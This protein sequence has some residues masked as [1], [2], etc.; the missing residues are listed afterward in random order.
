VKR[1]I[2]TETT[3]YECIAAPH[4]ADIKI[5]RDTILTTSDVT[6]CLQ[7]INELKMSKGLALA[8]IITNLAEQ[9]NELDV[10]VQTRV[11][12]L[13]GLSEIEYRLSGGG[14]ETV[15]TGGLV[16]V[17]RNGAELMANKSGK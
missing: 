3:I 11:T 12:W 13:E 14:S 10:P 17:I 6:S 2:I 1:E 8:D 5:I 15:Q 7:T 9:L 16:G 4:P